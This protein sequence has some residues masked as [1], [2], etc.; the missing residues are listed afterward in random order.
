MRDQYRKRAVPVPPTVEIQ[1]KTGMMFYE[2]QRMAVLMQNK[3][4]MLRTDERQTMIAK[5]WRALGHAGRAPWE[6]MADT[7]NQSIP[8]RK[9]ADALYARYTYALAAAKEVDPTTIP[10]WS[11]LNTADGDE[12]RCAAEEV[13]ERLKQDFRSAQTQSS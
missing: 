7:Y 10:S 9:K 11:K 12:F 2:K 6:V 1:R 13:H 8:K 4:Q 5:E 3:N